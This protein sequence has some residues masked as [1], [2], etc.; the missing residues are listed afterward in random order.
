MVAVLTGI[1][2][3]PAPPAAARATPHPSPGAASA[4]PAGGVPGVIIQAAGVGGGVDGEVDARVDSRRAAGPAGGVPADDRGHRGRRGHRRPVPG[5]VV[6]AVDIPDRPWEQGHRG[7]DLQAAPGDPVR[8]SAAGTVVFAGSVA[9]TPVVSVDHGGGLRTTYEPV[10]SDVRRGDVVTRGAVI[11]RLADAAALPST[12]RRVPGLSWGA[13]I[14]DPASPDGR[15][16]DPMSL[17]GR[18]TV[19][20]W[21]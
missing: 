12:A 1:T 2:V 7:V 21:A 14:R 8:A 9:G 13:R 6:R 15:Y 11:G 3:L 5:A 17:L 20:L 16:I 10:V 4:G 18:P 19:R